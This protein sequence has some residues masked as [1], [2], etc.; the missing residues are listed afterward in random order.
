MGSPFP[1]WTNKGQ[2][3]ICPKWSLWLCDKIVVNDNYQVVIG[4]TWV[5]TKVTNLV[6]QLTILVSLLTTIHNNYSYADNYFR[7]TI[8]YSFVTKS[9][10]SFKTNLRPS[11][12]CSSWNWRPQFIQLKF[13]CI[14][15]YYFPFKNVQHQ[16]KSGCCNCAFIYANFLKFQERKVLELAPRNARPPKRWVIVII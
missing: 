16:I 10:I 8:N 12:I 15:F 4:N 6:S 3:L 9:Q 13:K 1:T 5:V 11:L 2:C 14:F 7:I